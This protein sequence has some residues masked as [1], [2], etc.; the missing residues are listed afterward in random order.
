MSA[1]LAKEAERLKSDPIFAKALDTIRAEAL[2]ELAT[3]D[4]N[5]YTAIVRLQQRVAVA[6]EIRA[7]LDRYIMAADAQDTAGSYA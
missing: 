5:N 1:H 3:A 6:D 7:T 2:N 4:A